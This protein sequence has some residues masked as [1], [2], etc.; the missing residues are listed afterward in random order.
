M[1]LTTFF[2]ISAMTPSL[3]SMSPTPKVSEVVSNNEV[4]SIVYLKA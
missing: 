1:H 4:W 2:A 3:L